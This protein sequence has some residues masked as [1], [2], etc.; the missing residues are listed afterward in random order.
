[1]AKKSTFEE[2]KALRESN[3]PEFL[4]TVYK[5][6]DNRDFFS[7]ELCARSYEEVEDRNHKG[8]TITVAK[9]KYIYLTEEEKNELVG[10]LKV[11]WEK[12]KS[13]FLKEGNERFARAKTHEYRGL[14]PDEN[15]E[16]II[17]ASF[18][19]EIPDKSTFIMACKRL[20]RNREAGGYFWKSYM[21]KGFLRWSQVVEMLNTTGPKGTVVDIIY[22]KQP[23]RIGHE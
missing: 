2:L 9:E 11:K 4:N 21:F 16:L 7:A 19:K 14:Y 10:R 23:V 3:H 12:E 6:F 13:E 15:I 22:V 5:E 20:D 1:M 8:R 17:I 18:E